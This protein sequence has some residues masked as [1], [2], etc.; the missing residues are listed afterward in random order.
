MICDMPR[1]AKPIPG[2]LSRA[3]GS[4][5]RSRMTRLDVSVPDIANLLGLSDAQVNRIL[6]A[7]RH[8]DVEQL[9]SICQF[10]KLDIREVLNEAVAELG[11]ESSKV[12][13]IRSIAKSPAISPRAPKS[14]T[15]ARLRSTVDQLVGPDSASTLLPALS[16]AGMS[17]P[18]QTWTSFMT[19]DVDIEL[20]DR[21][22]DVIASAI[23]VRPSYFTTTDTDELARV[24]AEIE[25]ARVMEENGVTK[26][27]AR[28]LDQLPPETVS[29]ITE[30]IRSSNDMTS[31]S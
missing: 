11:V 26:I 7:S 13:P 20:D 17:V 1:G 3:I 10:L 29:A 16:A 6:R 22:L 31:N 9:F 23:G 21:A 8:I 12:A 27:A 2:P 25:L 24:E 19:G 28:A 18:S 14:V 5:V 4:I 30:L 15:A